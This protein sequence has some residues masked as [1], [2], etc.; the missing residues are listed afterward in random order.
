MKVRIN[1]NN[2]FLIIFIL[3][4]NILNYIIN[5]ILIFKSEKQSNKKSKFFEKGI[6]FGGLNK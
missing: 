5:N 6:N 3:K 4:K 2:V 1:R